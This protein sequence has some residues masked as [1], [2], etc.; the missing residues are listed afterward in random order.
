MEYK[1]ISESETKDVAKIIAREI[2]SKRGSGPLFVG[3][4]GDL[5]AGKLLL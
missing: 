4:I 3:L 2:I 5:G 1:T